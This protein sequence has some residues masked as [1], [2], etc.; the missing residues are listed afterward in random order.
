MKF[1]I[2]IFALLTLTLSSNF[3]AADT[4]ESGW[5]RPGFDYH[6]FDMNSTRVILCQ[7]NCQKD[8]RCKAWTYVR[9]GI[10]G[11]NPRCWL[12]NRVPN[13]VRNNCCT[14]GIIQ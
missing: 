1:F 7:W 6:S 13:P 8:K 9:A 4:F 3:A 2:Q 14:S 5:D 10:Q 11:P 12:K